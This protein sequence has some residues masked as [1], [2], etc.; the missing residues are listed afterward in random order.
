MPIAMEAAEISPPASL[1]DV[2]TLAVACRTRSKPAAAAALR[3]IWT[4]AESD[5]AATE[6]VRLLT[7]VLAPAEK[8]WLATHDGARKERPA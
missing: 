7:R 4:A 6:D 5:D 2:L 3:R 8:F 1:R